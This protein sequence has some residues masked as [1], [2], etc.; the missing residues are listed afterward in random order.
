MGANLFGHF[1]QLPFFLRAV[2]IL[3]RVENAYLE[4]EESIEVYPDDNKYL[5]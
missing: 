1:L 3:Y 4:N 5:G 2:S